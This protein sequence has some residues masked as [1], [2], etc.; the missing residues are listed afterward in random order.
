MRMRLRSRN[1][2]A[3]R[4]AFWFSPVRAGLRQRAVME[5][6][7]LKGKGF[8]IRISARFILVATMLLL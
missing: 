5:F 2:I 3:D 7:F 6:V 1:F 8:R 4:S